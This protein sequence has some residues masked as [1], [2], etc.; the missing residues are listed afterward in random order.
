MGT[1]G[2]TQETERESDSKVIIHS[3]FCR[4]FRLSWGFGICLGYYTEP[5]NTQLYPLLLQQ[6]L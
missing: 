1:R 2:E 3:I 5:P 4:P 6:N